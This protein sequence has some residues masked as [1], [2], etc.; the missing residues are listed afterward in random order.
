[1]NTNIQKANHILLHL[2]L[3]DGVGPAA[4]KK[5]INHK[6]T[7]YAWDAL[8]KFD[9]NTFMHIFGFT[10]HV[11]EKIVQ[12]LHDKSLLEK[13]LYLIAHHT[14]NWTTILNDDYPELLK[15][16][17]APPTILYWR[18]SMINN[19]EKTIALVG[20]RKA[21]HY[22]QRFINKVVPKLVH[23]NWTIVSGGALGL[24]SM[25]HHATVQEQGK[26]V[27]VLGSGLLH[28]YPRSN[29]KLFDQVIETGGLILSA[30]YLQ[31][32]AM[33]GNFPA[34]NRIISGLSKGCVVVQAAAKSGARITARYAL[35]QGRE[36]FAVPGPIDDPLS[37][38]CHLLIQ[39]GAQL[40]NGAE[41][42]LKEFGELDQKSD[43]K[44]IQ[45]K[46]QSIQSNDSIE[47]RIIVAC[48]RPCSTDDLVSQIGLSL[49]DL[50]AKL[51]DLQLM[52]S[53]SQDFTGMW[54]TQ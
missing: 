23:N 2:S 26:T 43:C 47:E 49:P 18:G 5:I 53:I 44:D 54:V 20:A 4:I 32:K 8:Y 39:E 42:I 33:P 21:N 38:G 45:N 16:I 28:L 25:A 7:E 15:H 50:Q 17:Y 35:E 6:P 3:L 9:V 24:D 31:M 1:M 52:G 12:G 41:D 34:R 27:V 22:G 30:F 11:A 14:I 29:I 13:E 51:F 36:V 48:N 10:Q 19:F 46:Q 40:V 37:A